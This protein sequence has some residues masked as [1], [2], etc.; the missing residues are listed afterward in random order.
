[1]YNTNKIELCYCVPI[2]GKP[3]GAKDSADPRQMSVCKPLIL[4]EKGTE[5][6]MSHTLF[7]FNI[8]R[9]T[10]ACGSQKSLNNN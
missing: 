2:E 7:M 3:E 10:A 5:N 1:M 6:E 9:Y 4:G 8:K